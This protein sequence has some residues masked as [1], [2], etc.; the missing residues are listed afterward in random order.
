MFVYLT[1]YSLFSAIASHILTVY[2]IYSLTHSQ[3]QEDAMI[4]NEAK[5]ASGKNLSARRHTPVLNW[6]SQENQN[7][8]KNYSVFT[9]TGEE[10]EKKKTKKRKANSNSVRLRMELNDVDEGLN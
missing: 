10:R 4:N 3:S 6:L 7:R 8:N 2:S 9:G 5:K 1:S